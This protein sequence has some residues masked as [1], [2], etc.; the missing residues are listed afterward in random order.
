MVLETFL[1]GF[2]YIFPA[3][4]ANA[5]PVVAVKLLGKA[6]P[7]DNRLYLPDGRRLL[8]DG[9]TIEGLIAG[10]AFGTLTGILINV[11]IFQLFRTFYE[12]LTIATGAM[13]GDILGAFIKR[14][15]GLPQGHPAPM[16]D[17]LGFLIAS[18]LLTHILF[19]LPQWLDIF[20]IILLLVLTFAMHVGTN[21]F[22]YSVG[23]K[24]RWY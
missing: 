18:L 9:K 14:R 22:A 24:D 3:Y 19:T 23:L 8:G 12:I 6:H 7:I 5:T 17:Q 11:F 21:L 20:T 10:I 2:G 15:L 16:L 1:M 4:V 13:A